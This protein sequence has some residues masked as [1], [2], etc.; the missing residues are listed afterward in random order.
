MTRFQPFLCATLMLSLPA[1][2]LVDQRDF[3]AHAGEK[4]QPAVAQAKPVHATPALVTIRYTTPAPDY[5]GALTTAVREALARKPDVL[6]T[7]TTLVPPAA[8]EDAGAD[9]AAAAAASGREVAQ[10]IVDA[11][12]APGQIEQLV[13]I[14]QG[15]ST[16][17]VIVR[18]Q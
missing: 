5:Q 12:A 7:V 10:T 17:E 6:F 13:T 14:D 4:P 1:C 9:A 11:G 15:T 3:N 2:H 18:V 16:R 8:T